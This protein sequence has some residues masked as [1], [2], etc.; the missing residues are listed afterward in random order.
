MN[1]ALL[2]FFKNLSIFR[3]IELLHSS[4]QSKTDGNITTTL[5]AT[6][7]SQDERIEQ[8]ALQYSLVDSPCNWDAARVVDQVWM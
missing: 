4:V 3:G 2:K 8:L 7:H 6:S 5:K 1:T